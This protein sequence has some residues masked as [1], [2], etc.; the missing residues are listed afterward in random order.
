MTNQEI[1]NWLEVNT[2]GL[3]VSKH[4]YHHHAYEI[5]NTHKGLHDDFIRGLTSD[6]SIVTSIRLIKKQKSRGIEAGNLNKELRKLLKVI[7]HH[8]VKFE[9]N[10]EKGVFYF[11]SEK[12]TIGGFDFAILNHTKNLHALRNLCFGELHYHD[13][14]K[15]WNKFLKKNE[16]LVAIAE[17]LKELENLGLDIEYN[18]KAGLTPLIM[19]EIQFGNWALVYRDFFKLLKANV[20]N[21]I[22]CL[23]YVVP[24]G[25]LENMLSDGIV[26][27][28]KTIKVLKDFAKVIS[29]PV[30]V[31]GLDLKQQ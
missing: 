27:F 1:E 22:D 18:E 9:V 25:N 10:E 14:E 23:I 16:D 17:R 5:M 11:S 19:G 15:R 28:D 12:S 7:P 13:G 8:E 20:Q 6:I 4:Y 24:T 26:T 31:V 2:G 3:F 29:V 30:W 21:S